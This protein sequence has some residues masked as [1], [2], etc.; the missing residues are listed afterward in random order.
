MAKALKLLN[1]IKSRKFAEALENG[2]STIKLLVSAS[3][4]EKAFNDLQTAQ[5]PLISFAPL[6]V[7]G[8]SNKRVAKVLV[9]FERGKLLAVIAIDAAGLITGFRL[10]PTTA[11]T[12]P[13]KQPSY[14]DPALFAE[15]EIT[16]TVKDIVVG[17]AISLPKDRRPIAG[18]VFLGGSGPTDKDSTIGPNKPLKDLAWGLASRQIA[19]CRWDKPS[20]DDSDKVTNEGMTLAKEYLPYTLAAVEHLRK[21]TS[22]AD[23][24]SP[25]PI[26]VLGHSLGGVIAPMVAEKDPSIKGL[27]LLS[28]GGDKMYH[29]ALRQL[30]YLV[31]LKHDPPFA[32]QEFVDVLKKQVQVIES[33]DFSQNTPADR[34]PFGAPASYWFDVKQYD[35]IARGAALDVPIAI[36][37]PGRDYQVTVEDDFQKWKDG[38]GSRSSVTMKVYDGLN[39]LLILSTDVD[40]S[41]SPDD[42][43]Q[44]GHVEERVIVD[45]CAWIKEHLAS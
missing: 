31:S 2:T 21:K 32:T 24:E 22:F 26:F 27:I 10:K 33:P 16:L 41:P 11:T 38:L 20:A 13:W 35:Q 36:L 9:N 23:A 17:A 19:V 7:D 5:G 39:H 37:Q 4:L 40:G 25:I 28:S 15:E 43:G 1:L 44:E 3:T 30:Q 12:S 8:Y 6:G 18:V 42:Y 29:S 34:L 45:I 14:V